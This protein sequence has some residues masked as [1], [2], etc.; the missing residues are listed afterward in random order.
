MMLDRPILRAKRAQMLVAVMALVLG[1]G[2]LTACGS[3]DSA[4]STSGGQ[5][6]T[7]SSPSSKSVEAVRQMVEAASSGAVF[8]PGAGPVTLP[9]EA[10]TPESGAESIKP[11]PLKPGGPPK[12]V[13]MV[14]CGPT[15]TCVHTSA[16]VKA[17]VEKLG[18][19]VE[20]VQSQDL[21]PAQQQA[22]WNTALGKKPDAIISFPA[23]AA[24]GPQLARAK[25]EGVY[26]VGIHTTTAAGKGY[27]AYVGGGWSLAASV[28]V[29]KMI[30]A[31]QSKSNIF[32][33]RLPALPTL[34]I[35]E[36]TAFLKQYCPDC[37]LVEQD[38]PVPTVLEPVPMGQFVTSTVRK[39]PDLDYFAVPSADVQVK[40]AVQAFRSA[41]SDAEV[42]GPALNGPTAMAGLN[43]GDLP[44]IA[45]APPEWV[46][47]Q[48][49]DAVIRGL[50]GEPA[51][52]ENDSKIGVYMMTKENAPDNPKNLDGPV[53]RWAVE[54]FDFVA[55]YSKAWNVDLSSVAADAE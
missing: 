42:V 33:A 17:I 52:P 35:A 22:T 43:S 41:G 15:A 51:V 34:G 2:G 44:F 7:T 53:D 45:G 16:L 18:W 31:G 4:D 3:S 36:G 54:Q 40:A 37:E 32:Y 6:S 13:V 9:V 47:L 24:I 29:A 25:R 38:V 26:T 20:V 21:S 28:L 19:R 48:G 23:A 11:F 12:S 5:E 8:G 50:A 10:L 30:D 49:V 1:A 39:Y 27:D 46:A 55:P 14:S